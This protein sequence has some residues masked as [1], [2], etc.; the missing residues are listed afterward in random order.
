M[1]QLN[2]LKNALAIGVVAAVVS[3]QSSMPAAEPAEKMVGKPA[4]N[5]KVDLLDGGK[6]ELASFKDKN[7]VILDFWATWCGPCR[8]ALPILSE[9]SEAYKDKGVIL[10][11]VDLREK[12]QVI[13]DYLAK[14]K[15]KLTVPLDTDGKIAD[16]YGVTGIPQTVIIGKDGNIK[17]VHI[18]YSPGIKE[19]LTKELDAIIA[20]KEVAASDH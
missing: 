16:S 8:S 14:S 15:L 18:G 11:P 5:F 17:A 9:V 7:I 2:R 10:R 20:G 19:R 12:P 6:F 13:K 4:P 3:V 1:M